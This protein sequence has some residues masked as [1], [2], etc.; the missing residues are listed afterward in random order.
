MAVRPAAAA[1][2]ALAARSPVPA[3]GSVPS[4]TGATRR[5]DLARRWA[6]AVLA[7]VAVTAV[8]GGPAGLVCGLGVA[9]GAGRYLARL[10]PKAVR[11]ERARAAED[12]PYAVDLLAAALRAGQ[13]TQRAVGVV[14]A[15]VDGPIGRR[16][17][18]VARALGLGLPPE[19]AWLALADLPGGHRLIAAVT[20]SADSG[21]ALSAT[22]VRLADDQRAQ[23]VAA[24]DAAARRA[25]VL[26]VLP[27]GLCFL[28]AFVF[29][30]VVPVIVAVLGDVLRN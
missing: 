7:G 24:V 2:R 18:R 16:L 28:P 12:L 27:L 23:R 22:F 19:R 30:G 17:G 26:V 29:A 3:G 10:E 6:V 15:A 14:A 20:R 9:A 5:S 13:P 25:G 4:G 21:A 11:V 8:V 1:R